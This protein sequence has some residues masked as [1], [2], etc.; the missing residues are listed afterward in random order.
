MPIFFFHFWSSSH[1]L[2]PS[3]FT[4]HF[5]PSHSSPHAASLLA[6]LAMITHP[7]KQILSLCALPVCYA[8][9]VVCKCACVCGNVHACL[10]DWYEG[11]TSHLLVWNEWWINDSIIQSECGQYAGAEY[12]KASKL[13]CQCK[14]ISRRGERCWTYGAFPR[15]PLLFTWTSTQMCWR[16]QLTCVYTCGDVLKKCLTFNDHSCLFLPQPKTTRCLV[17]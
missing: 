17:D 5:V 12:L 2:F 16:C 10:T 3:S 14:A 1:A 15:R 9:S 4:P 6:Q 7:G 13:I 11:S 8:R